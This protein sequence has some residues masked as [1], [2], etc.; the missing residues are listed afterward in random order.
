MS[1][2]YSKTK[3]KALKEALAAKDWTAVEKNAS[4]VLTFEGSNYNAR[5]FL[6]LALFNLGKFEESEENYKKAIEG[7]PTQPLARQ[8]LASFYEKRNRWSDYAWSLQ[9]LMQLFEQSGDAIKYGESLQKFI[10]VR[11]AHGTVPELIQALSLIIPSS[12]TW[13]LLRQLPPA[14]PTAPLASSVHTLQLALQSALPTLLEITTLTETLESNALTSEVNKRR[15]RLGGTTLSAAETRRR[16][17]AEQLPTSALPA[18]YRSLLDDPDAASDD[19]L[20]RSVERKLLDHLGNLLKALPSRFDG[21]NLDLKA[22]EK[23]KEARDEEEFV[24]GHVRE[25]VER[26]SHDMV[27]IGVKE[28]K[29]WMTVLDWSD[30]NSTWDTVDWREVGRY[31]ETF[32][33]TGLANIARASQILRDTAEAPNLDS[34]DNATKPVPPSEEEMLQI[35]EDGLAASPD[36]LLAHILSSHYLSDKREWEPLVQISE[37]GL[38]LLLR[39]EK[40]IGRALAKSRRTLESHLAIS[41]VHFN[42][43]VHHLRALRLLESLLAPPNKPAIPLLSAKAY[44]LQHSEKWVQAVDAWDAVI[45]ASGSSVEPSLEVQEERSWCLYNAGELETARE[46]LKDVVRELE[47]RKQ[48]RD[49]ER[50]AKEIARSKAGQERGEGVEEGETSVETLERAT[51][52]WR[53]GKCLWD[54]GETDPSQNEPAYDAFIAAVFASPTFAPAFT[55]LGIFY[56][57]VDPPDYKR[58]SQC[59]EKAFELDNGQEIAARYLAEEFA[60]IGEWSLVESIARRIVEG[61]GSRAA[62]GGKAAQRLSWAF[63][64]LGGAELNIKRYP[65]AISAFLSALRG[66]P[67]DVHTWIRLGVAYRGSGKHIAALKVFAR[68]LEID[69]TSWFAKYSIG[70]VQRD[71]GLLE[72]AIKS[73]RSILEDRPKEV[74]VRVVL[75]ETLLAAGAEQLRSG[76]PIRAE[77]SLMSAIEEACSMISDGSPTRIAWKVAADAAAA[78]SKISG[79]TPIPVVEKLIEQLERQAVDSK[80][81]GMTAIK[82]SSLRPILTTGSPSNIW[83]ALAALGYKMRVLLETQNEASIGSA[84]FDFGLSLWNL[85]SQGADLLRDSGS[86]ELALQQSVRCLK[87]A[88]HKE[89]YNPLFWNALG[90]VAFDLSPRLSQH[91]FIKAIEHNAR[92]AVPWANLGLFYTVH[93]DDDLAN[94]AFLKAQVLDPDF[95][96]AWV[97]QATLARQAGHFTEA[98]VLLHHAFTIGSDT[99]EADLGFATSSFAQYRSSS[100]SSL[101]PAESLSGPLFAL[102]RYLSRRPQDVSALHLNALILEQL[103]DHETASASLEEAASLL[104]DLYD[105]DESPEVEARFIIAQSN[106]GRVRLANEDHEGAITAFDFALNL[107]PSPSSLP[108]NP[109]AESGLSREQ[110]ILLY[111]ECKLGMGLAQFWLGE[112]ST[113]LELLSEGLEELESVTSSKKADLAVS[114]CRIYWSEE[115]EDRALSALLDSPDV[116]SIKSSMVVKLTLQ[117]LAILTSDKALMEVV[118]RVHQHPEAKYNLDATRMNALERL[119]KEDEAGALDIISR[120]LHA[121]PWENSNR[122]SLARIL[123]ELTPRPGPDSPNINLEICSRFLRTKNVVGETTDSKARR[124]IGGATIFAAQEGKETEALSMLEKAVWSAPW[125]SAARHALSSFVETTKH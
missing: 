12:P 111:T 43:P 88:L 108:E 104:S 74:G 71:I 98:S 116:E 94:Q 97:G 57:T 44:V 89:P 42:P 85:R 81:E 2:S 14:N 3:M 80:I 20:R 40:E 19:E 73:F 90:V 22:Q 16:V 91:A 45:A 27:L 125:H 21:P 32:P 55:S 93:G 112:T 103:G 7:A 62:M 33:Q 109:S 46:A 124:L 86:K 95:V 118:K 31:V 70:D 84:W 114:L 17:E 49:E 120:T 30:R 4:D 53:L 38:A 25:E 123:I 41:L 82:V 121:A 77:E 65:N 26:L 11:R 59:F 56:R 37:A 15:Q 119:L 8:G 76:F 117:A 1:S 67:G 78:L 24:K 99:P 23:R 115:D 87:F 68:A 5:V 29:A 47:K 18:L 13:S 54:L 79:A 58:A 50:K 72:P 61:A 36:S 96:P 28:E 6:A 107:I 101:T 69:P 34:A 52:W 51:A 63:K 10:E 35:I 83:S 48:V 106:L 39:I 105:S 60:E 110:A 66:A 9:E 102:T 122:R 100:D 113:A 75:A 92:S 64:A